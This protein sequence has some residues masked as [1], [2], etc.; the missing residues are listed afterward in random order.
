VFDS[1]VARAP[2]T[3]TQTSACSAS[4]RILSNG[5]WGVALLAFA[6][7]VEWHGRTLKLLRWSNRVLSF[8]MNVGL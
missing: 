1:S 5:A 7:D 8:E 4:L 3:T 2:S 6:A